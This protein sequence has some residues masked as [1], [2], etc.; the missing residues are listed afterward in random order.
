M[1]LIMTCAAAIIGFMVEPAWTYPIVPDPEMTQGDLCS[2]KD[3]DFTQH[4]YQE[5]IPYCKR[6]VSWYR[7]EQI[8]NAYNIPQDCRHRYTVDHFIPL[9][10]GG[11]NDDV[12]LWPEHVQVKATRPT[13]EQELFLALDRGEITQKYALE[14]ITAEKMK[15]RARLALHFGLDNKKKVKSPCDQP[16]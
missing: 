7:R 8:Y 14:V 2:E 6:N 16:W 3:P 12:N 4:R 15:A 5:N 13:L 1:K 9:A 11:N 10:L